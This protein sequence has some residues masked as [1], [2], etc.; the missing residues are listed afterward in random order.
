MTKKECTVPKRRT[1]PKKHE[2]NNSEFV[3]VDADR[4]QMYLSAKTQKRIADIDAYITAKPG[5]N[6]TTLVRGRYGLFCAMR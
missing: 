2:S 1:E 4:V 5:P 3:I 6:G